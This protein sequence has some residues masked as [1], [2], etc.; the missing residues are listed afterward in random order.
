MLELNV[1]MSIIQDTVAGPR[2]TI[3]TMTTTGGI[4][5]YV[6]SIFDDVSVRD[7]YAISGNKVVTTRAINVNE[8]LNFAVHVVDQGDPQDSATSG[9]MV[10][11]MQAAAQNMF[12]KTNVIYKITKDIN[13]Y[14][15]AL[16]IPAGCTLSFNG[17][18]LL[19]GT[20]VLNNTKVL[21]QAC[22]I[23][24]YISNITINGTYKEGQILYDK[25]LTPKKMKMWNGT[26]W[27]NMDGSA[28]A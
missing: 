18:R 1:K 27:V 28:L 19:N 15:K 14:G 20:I 16:T 8:A 3:C 11:V 26:A 24:D 6:Y 9:L 5:P 10:P 7:T 2:T 21:P 12:N 13:L 22:D 23:T 25:T 17:G 4:A